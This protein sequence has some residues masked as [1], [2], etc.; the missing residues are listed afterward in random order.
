M[1]RSYIAG[2]GLIPIGDHWSKSIVDLAAEASIEA[3]S[4]AGVKKPE[5][6]VVGN[7]FS[8]L[9]SSQEHLG[10]LVTNAV[11]LTGTPAFKV[12]DACASGAAALS[13]ANAFIKSGQ[14]RSALVVGVE[15]MR[16]LEPGEVTRALSMAESYEYTQFVGVSFVALNAM[17]ARLYLENY[18]VSRDE[19]S[20]FPVLAHKNSANAKHAQF[21]KPI[22]PE[23]VVRSPMISDPL[24]LLDCSPIGDGAAALVLVDEGAASDVK[25]GLV[26]VSASSSATNRFSAYEREDMLDL[27]ATRSATEKALAA[28]GVSKSSVDLIEVHDAFSVVA[29]LSVEAMGFSKRGEGC[30]DAYAGVYSR[31]GKHPALTFGGLKG[32]GHPVGATGIYQAAEASLQLTGK[33]EQNQIEGAETA[34]VQN[35]GGVDT[36][37]YIHVLKAK[38]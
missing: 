10:P 11:G 15:K 2:V 29:A 3:I 14:V 27:A 28:A 18:E 31:E 7:M 8:S 26:E 34:L 23:D 22:T 1:T 9:S 30:R 13:A 25:G 12:E 35:I 32:R 16:D 36:C 20:A 5:L 17:L 24:R 4:S 21:R 33:A 38:K 6:V 19:L 37:A